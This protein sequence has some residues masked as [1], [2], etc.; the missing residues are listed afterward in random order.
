MNVESIDL[1]DSGFPTDTFADIQPANWA[2]GVQ[3]PGLMRGFQQVF[4]AT[5]W[6]FGLSTAP[7]RN[8]GGVGA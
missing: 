8:I 6:S 7:G 5:K 3:R 2:V 1:L 4:N